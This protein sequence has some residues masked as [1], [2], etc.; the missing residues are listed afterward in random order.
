MPTPLQ[1]LHQIGLLYIALRFHLAPQTRAAVLKL[2]GELTWIGK[3]NRPRLE[4]RILLEGPE[5]SCHAAHRVIGLSAG[6]QAGRDLFGNQYLCG[7]VRRRKRPLPRSQDSRLLSMDK[8]DILV[9]HEV[10]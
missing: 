7:V 4:P 5:K 6:A 2:A 1:Y 10:G 8:P 3:E 9:C